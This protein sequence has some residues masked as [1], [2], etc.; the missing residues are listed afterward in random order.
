MGKLI[1]YILLILF[2]HSILHARNLPE[3]LN[4]STIIIAS[5]TSLVNPSLHGFIEYVTF[6]QLTQKN[7]ELAN[8]SAKRYC[9]KTSKERAWIMINLTR[10]YHVQNITLKQNSH[11][12]L[13]NVEILVGFYSCNPLSFEK[14]RNKACQV[15][16]QASNTP[17]IHVSCGIDGQYV[18]I[19]TTV[20]NVL[21]ICDFNVHVERYD[22]MNERGGTDKNDLLLKCISWSDWDDWSHCSVSCGQG[23]RIRRRYCDNGFGFCGLNCT[24]FNT[25]L[26]CELLKAELERKNIIETGCPG[27]D[28]PKLIHICPKTCGICQRGTV[29]NQQ[30]QAALCFCKDCN[31][32]DPIPDYHCN[33]TN[34]L[35]VNQVEDVR[36][37]LKKYLGEQGYY[38]FRVTT[39]TSPFDETL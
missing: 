10:P 5:S 28:D 17:E 7:K 8:N 29:F 34:T 22:S 9:A 38:D 35:I 16:T 21:S 33:L 2:L 4:I 3:Y 36:S 39:T 19:F 15:I 18:I 1:V 32:D 27:I 25:G 24:D 11:F 26:E 14:A 20:E 37:E 31:A 23:T 6:D 12:P 13:R 30:T